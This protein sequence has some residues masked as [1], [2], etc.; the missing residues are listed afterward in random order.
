M[1]KTIKRIGKILVDFPKEKEISMPALGVL[2]ALRDLEL[3]RTIKT[4][5]NL[6]NQQLE[7][8]RELAD[9]YAPDLA[10][11]ISTADSNTVSRQTSNAS[12]N[13]PTYDKKSPVRKLNE[14]NE[15]K[16]GTAPFFHDYD[17]VMPEDEILPSGPGTKQASSHGFVESRLYPDSQENDEF[18]DQCIDCV[19]HLKRLSIG[20]HSNTQTHKVTSKSKAY[21]THLLVEHYSDEDTIRQIIDELL[22]GS[23]S[24]HNAT[25]L[26]LLLSDLILKE[27]PPVLQALIK[28]EK[29]ILSLLTQSQI[30]PILRD[31]TTPLVTTFNH[32]H[33]NVRKSVVFCLVELYF[34]VGDSFES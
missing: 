31:V 22:D 29:Y 20:A 24:D 21:Y 32:P 12:N 18:G 3:T 15:D 7:I 10:S 5:M 23:Y 25:E 13:Y 14:V 30:L 11:N 33:A 27:E 16:R 19:S 6:P 17:Q 2:L 26:M 9:S 28:T 1:K 34:A 8:I 4:I